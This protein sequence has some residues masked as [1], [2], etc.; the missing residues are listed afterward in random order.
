MKMKKITGDF[1]VERAERLTQD[2][3]LLFL[4][5]VDEFLPEICPGQFV[6]I[7]VAASRNTFLRRP[8]S[9]CDVTDD[10]RLVLLVKRAGDATAVLCDSR[11]GDIYNILL[12]LGKGFGFPS[13]KRSRI[14]LAG[15]GVGVAPLYYYGR[16]LKEAGYSP[17]FLLGAAK[18][19]DLYLCDRFGET[20]ELFLSTMDGSAGEKGLVTENSVMT[21]D[22]DFIACCG[23]LPMMKAVARIACARGIECEVSLENRMACGLGAC[24]CCVEDTSDHGNV[25]VC[26][27]GPV[28]NIKELKW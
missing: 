9:V 1:R 5:P 12:P 25:C 8:I 28:F 20:G 19:S 6:N 22:F 18:K 16:K 15:G 17:S 4:E 27:D 24:L 14:L 3:T 7:Y 21:R 2:C 11:K 23:P 13:D 10:G 26:K